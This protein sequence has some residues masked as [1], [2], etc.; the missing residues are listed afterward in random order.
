MRGFCLVYN[1]ARSV[2]PVKQ[3]ALGFH[4]FTPVS[5]FPPI[6][7]FIKFLYHFINEAVPKLQFWNRFLPLEKKE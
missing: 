2:Q 4:R 7:L 3:H 1:N 5:A 6:A